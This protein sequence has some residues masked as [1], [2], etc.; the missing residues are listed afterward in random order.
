MFRSYCQHLEQ[1]FI[2]IAGDHSQNLHH[3]PP[4][5]LVDVVPAV[6]KVYNAKLFLKQR[7]ESPLDFGH[8]INY[9]RDTVIPSTRSSALQNYTKSRVALLPDDD[10]ILVSMKRSCSAQQQLR[11]NELHLIFGSVAFSSMTITYRGQTVSL[12]TC[13][14]APLGLG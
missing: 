7:D 8:R 12:Y 11:S 10:W 9:A 5:K 3:L 2:R 4:P 13:A 6:I 14:A 1:N